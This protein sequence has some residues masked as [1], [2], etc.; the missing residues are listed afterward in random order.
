MAR[1]RFLSEQS[2]HTG[3]LAYLF[4]Q[5]LTELPYPVLIE[6][7]DERYDYVVA[8]TPVVDEV[9]LFHSVWQP[10]EA[11]YYLASDIFGELYYDQQNAITEDYA[12]WE[13]LRMI[14]NFAGSNTLDSRDY[15]SFL[16][17]EKAR[18][19]SYNAGFSVPPASL[20]TIA[21]VYLETN[22]LMFPHPT[23]ASFAPA[24]LLLMLGVPRE[25]VAVFGFYY[26]DPT[27]YYRRDS[28]WRAGFL[29]GTPY[30][31]VLGVLIGEQWIPVD[32]MLLPYYDGGAMPH[33]PQPH[34]WPS[35]LGYHPDDGR[36][37]VI[38]Y[39]HPYTMIFAPSWDYNDT[40]LVPEMSRIPLLTDQWIY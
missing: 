27:V 33:D 23:T 11:M 7:I 35:E 16:I 30:Y 15:V 29:T 39:A 19:L 1:K 20:A 34:S 4:A 38:D 3:R 28:D 31:T 40:Y 21:E 9:G 22:A 18:Q 37:L 24:S 2:L 25:R 10:T 13:A 17:K 6:P 5:G 8:R 32:F 14:H 12:I 26:Q 36:P